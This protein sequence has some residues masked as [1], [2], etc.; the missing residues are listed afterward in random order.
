M[1]PCLD[2]RGLKMFNLHSTLAGA[3]ALAAAFVGT[4]AFAGTTFFSKSA[5]DVFL[6]P[7]NTPVVSVTLP[8]GNWVLQ[9]TLASSYFD[10]TAVSVSCALSGA[11][12][13]SGGLIQSGNG[14]GVGRA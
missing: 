4:N 12:Q 7:A 14:G 13:S 5:S 3:A 11:H 10:P 8:K 1:P 9:A 2:R 6:G